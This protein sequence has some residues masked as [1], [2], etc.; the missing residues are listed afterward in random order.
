MSERFKSEIALDFTL[1]DTQ[2]RTVHL[3]DYIGQRTV[4][5]VLNRGFR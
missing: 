2:G 4:V 5:L 3:S 1:V